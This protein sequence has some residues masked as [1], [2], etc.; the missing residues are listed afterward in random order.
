[1][2]NS[3]GIR[4]IRL[5][6]VFNRALDQS[7]SKLQ[8]WDKVSSCFPQYVNTKQGAINVANCQRQLTEFWTELCQRE[9]KEIIEERDVEQKLNE[10][11]ELISEA[12]DRYTGSAHNDENERPAIDELSSRELVECHVYSQRIHAVQ[13][14]D[15]RL[16]KVNEMNDQLARELDDLEVQVEAEKR[17]INEMYDEYLGSHTDQ[18]VDGLLVQ[19]L[20]DMVLELKENY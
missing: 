13:E 11:D 16:A 19:S 3:H 8:S 10:L 7:I 17:E 1:M 6:Q 9:F 5:K 18:P 12:K 4:Y 14:I 20:S 15:E 2:A